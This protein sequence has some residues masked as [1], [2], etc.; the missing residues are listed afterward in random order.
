MNELKIK[1]GIKLFLEGLGLDI[2]DQHLKNTPTRVARAWI[3][4]FA[5]GYL[6]DTKDILS[7]EFDEK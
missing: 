5:S 2:R 7:V 1:E 4:T 3:D 6:Q